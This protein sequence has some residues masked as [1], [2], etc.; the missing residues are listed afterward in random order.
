MD[1]LHSIQYILVKSMDLESDDQVLTPAPDNWGL[2]ASCL[3]TDTVSSSAHRCLSQTRCQ[4]SL[5]S[6]ADVYFYV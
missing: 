3:T 2:G 6:N 1:V 4:E 5:D